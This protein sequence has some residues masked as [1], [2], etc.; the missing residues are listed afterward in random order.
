MKSF[1][2]K[3]SI[4]NGIPTLEYDVQ[5]IG[6]YDRE[7][8][9]MGDFVMMQDAKSSECVLGY[10]N[11]DNLEVVGQM[12]SREESLEFLDL[13]IKNMNFQ[14]IFKYLYPDGKERIPKHTWKQDGDKSIC[15]VNRKKVAEDSKII[16][17]EAIAENK[18]VRDCIY[19]NELPEVD[20]D[21][22][23]PAQ[24]SSYTNDSGEVKYGNFK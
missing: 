8:E 21:G 18:F 2:V 5:M 4:Q 11:A 17:E 15:F 7:G 24:R 23:K 19:K 12:D 16:P 14:K 1:K 3:M 9:C 6:E 13:Y 10:F 20:Y 22:S